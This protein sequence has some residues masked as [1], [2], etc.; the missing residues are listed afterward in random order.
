MAPAPDVEP[1]SRLPVG[2]RVEVRTGFDHTWSRGFEVVEDTGDGYRIR[3]RSDD[4]VL[5]AVFD[6]DEV[7][8]EHHRSMWWI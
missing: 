4:S 5:P 7:R 1:E 3:R 6:D 2:T 8:R